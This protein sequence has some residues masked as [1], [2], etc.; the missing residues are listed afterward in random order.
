MIYLKMSS[1]YMDYN[2]SSKTKRRNAYAKAGMRMA[3]QN[4]EKW[5]AEFVTS[6]YAESGKRGASWNVNLMGEPVG[7]IHPSG[8][9]TDFNNDDYTDFVIPC[10]GYDEKPWP[11]E[12]SVVAIGNGANNYT[13]LGGV[14]FYHDGD[15]ADFNMMAHGY[16]TTEHEQ[17]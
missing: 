7:C 14:G 9:P 11:G 8:I 13:D 6:Y 4:P 5:S 16:S 3:K 12:K 1:T 2:W 15:V 17:K 10:H